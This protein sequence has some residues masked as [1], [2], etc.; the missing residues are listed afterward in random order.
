[1]DGDEGCDGA[2]EAGCWRIRRSPDI[3]SPRS[4]SDMMGDFGVG[5][6]IGDP[7]SK[8]TRSFPSSVGLLAPKSRSP[9]LLFF[10]SLSMSSASSVLSSCET[11]CRMPESAKKDKALVNA[12]NKGCKPLQQ[13][14][15]TGASARSLLFRI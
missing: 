1:M 4:C 13:R 15:K 2:R 14:E 11:T 5:S 10:G 12:P 3:P 9:V 7:A 6:P 8:E